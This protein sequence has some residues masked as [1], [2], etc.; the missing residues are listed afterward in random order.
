MGKWFGLD[1]KFY[2][3][4]T[5]LADLIILTI[6]WLICSIPVITIGASTTALYYVTTRQLSNREGYVSRDFFRSFKQNFLEATAMTL[7]L[8]VIAVVLF[9]NINLFVPDSTINTIIYL[10]QYVLLYELLIFSIYVFPV[11][12]RFDLKLGALIKTSIF[13]ANRHLLTTF[14]CALLF[15]A[16]VMIVLKCGILIILCAG[17]YAIL[18]SLMF[19]KLFRKY[20]PD[21]DKD[22][23]EDKI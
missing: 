17:A 15:V 3:Y 13:M 6:L 20:V 16:I 7:I 1:S 4:G 11:L 14:T 5:L 12:S 2:K 23:P 21:M 9:I 10:I 18:T 22:K 19:M 8:G